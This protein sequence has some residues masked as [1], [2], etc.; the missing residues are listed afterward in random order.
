VATNILIKEKM[1]PKRFVQHE[2]AAVQRAQQAAV[3]KA[4]QAAVEKA[5]QAAVDSP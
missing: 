3:E 1:T 2:H 5:Q 4:Q